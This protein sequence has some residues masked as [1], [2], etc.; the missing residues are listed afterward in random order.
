V[1]RIRAVRQ[2]VENRVSKSGGHPPIRSAADAL[3]KKLKTVEEEL[4]QVQNRS[5]QDPLNFP[6]KLN[7]R[8]AA[9]RRSVETGDA[10]PTDASY[11]VLE[12]QT[13]ILRNLLGQ[14]DNALSVELASFNKL[15]A[16]RKLAPVEAK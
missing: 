8:L 14:L 15:L 10:R 7:N 2:Q 16:Q 1:V 13:A 4:Y 9:L 6:I 3:N 12:E 11:V 5:S